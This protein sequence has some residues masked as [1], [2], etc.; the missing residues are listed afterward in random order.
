MRARIQEQDGLLRIANPPFSNISIRNSIEINLTLSFAYDATFWANNG[1]S[2]LVRI[3][4]ENVN[5]PQIEN[6]F[7]FD[8]IPE[9]LFSETSSVLKKVNITL[10]SGIDSQ[11]TDAKNGGLIDYIYDLPPEEVEGGNTSSKTVTQQALIEK[12]VQLKSD[13]ALI[14]LGNRK[15]DDPIND[16]DF[17]END[18]KSY[19]LIS[20]E[21]SSSFSEIK[22]GLVLT[23]NQ[24]VNYT[25]YEFTYL[26]NGLPIDKEIVNISEYTGRLLEEISQVSSATTSNSYFRKFPTLSSVYAIPFPYEEITNPRGNGI[27]RRQNF[28]LNGTVNS[29]FSSSVNGTEIV[30]TQQRS[31]AIPFYVN[32]DSSTIVLSKPLP[33]DTSELIVDFLPTNSSLQTVSFLLS[34]NRQLNSINIPTDLVDKQTY[35]I[36]LS[37]RLRNGNVLVNIFRI[38]FRHFSVITN[39][40]TISSFVIE[41]LANGNRKVTA[42]IRTRESSVADQ[43]DIISKGSGQQNPYELNSQNFASLFTCRFEKI[44]LKTGSQDFSNEIIADN[45]GNFVFEDDSNLEGQIAYSVSFAQKDPNAINPTNQSSYAFGK[46]GGRYLSS[47]PSKSAI[48]QQSQTGPTF[49][50]CEIGLRS[51][52]VISPT[53]VSSTISYLRI[54]KTISGFTILNWLLNGSIDTIDHFQV[55]GKWGGTERLLGC[56]FRSLSYVDSKLW[57]KVGIVSYRIVPIYLDFSIGPSV[58]ASIETSSSLPLF[59]RDEFYQGITS[60]Q[61]IVEVNFSTPTSNIEGTQSKTLSDDSTTREPDKKEKGP[62]I[63]LSSPARN[64]NNPVAQIE[65]QVSSPAVNITKKIQ[66]LQAVTT[67]EAFTK[68]TSKATIQRVKLT[69]NRKA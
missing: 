53:I 5:K 64:I 62:T 52:G 61:N 3:L 31:F 58:I 2:V 56:S 26:L 49:S 43:Q 4:R 12:I 36:R 55:Y 6:N 22:H 28:N 39:A 29:S 21:K 57:E 63:Q 60:L 35:N 1:G 59:I 13:P 20:G 27:I 65:R 67:N 15:F 23:Q 19:R 24:F 37:I 7:G 44:T 47:L 46:F 69:K 34:A 30:N 68:A 51:T 25:I 33:Y 48:L 9:D 18:G 40:A 54:S 45:D 8:S 32:Y 17:Y 42:K 11:I 41:Q 38:S 14:G 16:D 66:V 10:G 50:S